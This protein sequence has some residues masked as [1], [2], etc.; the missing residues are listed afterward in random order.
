MSKEAWIMLII[1]I[2]VL[3]I[4]GIGFSIYKALKK[5]K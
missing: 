1:G 3:Y 5:K 4:Y 2:V